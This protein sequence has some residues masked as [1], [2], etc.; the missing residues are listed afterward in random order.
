VVTPKY[1]VVIRGKLEWNNGRSTNLD[2]R[3]ME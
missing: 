1:P 3:F 2:Q